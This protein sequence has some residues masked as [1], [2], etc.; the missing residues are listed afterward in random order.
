MEDDFN[1]D[2]R[3]AE[4]HEPF[5][6]SGDGEMVEELNRLELRVV[7]PTEDDNVVPRVSDEFVP[8]YRQS[9]EVTAEADALPEFSGPQFQYGVARLRIA[10]GENEH[11][12]T[13]EVVLLRVDETERPKSEEAT[14]EE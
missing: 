6:D 2:S 8:L 3:A 7:N 10:T 1:D 12:Q 4:W 5:V 11:E 13:L 14:E 9:F